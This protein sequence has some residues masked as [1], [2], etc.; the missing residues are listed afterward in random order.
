MRNKLKQ[1]KALLELCNN[2]TE[3]LGE[4]LKHQSKILT[5]QNSLYFSKCALEARIRGKGEV[6]CFSA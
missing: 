6:S 1:G 5:N 2:T 3:R 4:M